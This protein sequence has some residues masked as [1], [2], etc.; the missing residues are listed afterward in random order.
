MTV[1]CMLGLN[2][3]PVHG[4]KCGNTELVVK[5][6]E[7]TPIREYVDDKACTMDTL[8]N[9]K[10]GYGPGVSHIGEQ[11]MAKDGVNDCSVFDIQTGVNST[12]KQALGL[13]WINPVDDSEQERADNAW[14]EDPPMFE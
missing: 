4:S 2:S 1:V 12:D 5:R 8:N 13:Q 14:G 3:G 9:K 11:L 7:G 6:G 10:G